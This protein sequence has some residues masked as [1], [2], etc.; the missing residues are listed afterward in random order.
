[1]K[2]DAT[3]QLNTLSQLNQQ[4]K[5]IAQQR[6][7]SQVSAMFN[8]AN[9]RQQAQNNIKEQARWLTTT[10]GADGI[11]NAYKA[12]PRQLA[13]LEKNLG[14]APGGLQSL[15]TTAASERARKIQMENMD[16]A[17]KQA[18]INASNASTAKSVYE[19]NQLK[20]PSTDLS[21]AGGTIGDIGALAKDS[22]L[23]SAVGPNMLAR[24][25]IFNPLTG[26][27]AD[28]IAGIEQLR[29]QLTLDKLGEA[30]ASGATFGALS[31]GERQ[32]VAAAATK[33]GS[34]AI[35]DKEGKVT[36]YETS[37]AAF[38]KE[39][40]KINNF[41]KLDYIKKGG[42][43]VEVGVQKLPDGAYWT[44]NSDGTFTKLN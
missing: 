37:D 39:L 15:A 5:A 25:N 4:D 21:R 36:G 27:K 22:A 13:M 1:M 9:F 16:I 34:W 19:L 14:V 35:K 43:P 30:K 42:D 33:I 40:D 11:Y 3:N 24:F 2:T 23:S 18:S 32:T 31:D 28:F 38:K 44:Q 12:D 20:N 41:K 29:E 8:M 10:M 6:V 26:K 17:A 7:D